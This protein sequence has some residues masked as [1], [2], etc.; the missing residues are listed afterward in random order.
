MRGRSQSVPEKWTT[1]YTCRKDRALAASRILRGTKRLGYEPPI[2]SKAGLDTLSASWLPLDWLGHGYFANVPALID[3][4]RAIVRSQRAPCRLA[5]SPP[6]GEWKS[7]PLLE[8]AAEGLRPFARGH[9]R[10]PRTLFSRSRE[11]RMTV[12]DTLPFA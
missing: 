1:V 10:G 9:R 4:L 5:A 2:Y 11:R 12:P 6:S 3:D 8:I 7:T